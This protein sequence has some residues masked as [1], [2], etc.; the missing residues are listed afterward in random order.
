[1]SIRK[2]LNQIVS[3]VVCLLVG[4]ASATP[5]LSFHT[6]KHTGEK[7]QTCCCQGSGDNTIVPRDRNIDNSECCE[8]APDTR[9]GDDPFNP[10]DLRKSCCDIQNFDKSSLTREAGKQKKN[11]SATSNPKP[12]PYYA[13]F[14]DNQFLRCLLSG[15]GLIPWLPPGNDLSQLSR[16]TLHCSYLIFYFLLD[17]PKNC[18]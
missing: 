4:V 16:Y 6:C 8:Y 18:C 12:G 17:S 9:S 14:A 13:Q 15:D 3:V 11:E 2:L 10:C 5:S 1:M 7:N